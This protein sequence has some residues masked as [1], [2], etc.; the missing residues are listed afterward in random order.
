MRH[1]LLTKILAIT[2]LLS[3]QGITYAASSDSNKA[4]ST[5]SKNNDAELSNESIKS[6]EKKAEIQLSGL[7]KESIKKVI[8]ELAETGKASPSAAMMFANGGIKEVDVKNSKGMPDYAK[9]RVYRI[10]LR[11]AARHHTIV[12]CVIYYTVDDKLKDGTVKHLL[13]AEYEHVLGVSSTRVIPYKVENGKVL[14]GKP[15]DKRKP[16]LIFYDPNVSN[17]KT[18]K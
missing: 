17:P 10:A 9:V 11:A 8:K 2:L 18:S 15:V 12:A 6:M 16:F 14:F 1:K 4:T 13:V 7:F 3:W 5:E